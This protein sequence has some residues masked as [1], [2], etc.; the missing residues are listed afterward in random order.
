MKLQIR[1]RAD[2]EAERAQVQRDAARA[3]AQ[4]Y[5]AA[6]DWMVV[7][8]SETGAA[9]ADTVLAARAEARALLSAP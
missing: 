8:Q 1:T 2:L 3:K 5:L 6:T 9:M 4:A 7:R